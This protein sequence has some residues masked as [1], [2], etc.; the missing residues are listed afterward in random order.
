MTALEKS[1]VKCKLYCLSGDKMGKII[2][3]ELLPLFYTIAHY[4]NGDLCW[5]WVIFHQKT[6]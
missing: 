1:E 4:H 2:R 5:F 6:F 3:N